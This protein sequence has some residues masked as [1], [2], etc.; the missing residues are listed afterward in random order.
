MPQ[1][2]KP[3]DLQPFPTLLAL[4]FC[5]H[6][7][8][9]RARRSGAAQG[10]ATSWLPSILLLALLLCAGLGGSP[11]L[12]QGRQLSACVRTVLAGVEVM[13]SGVG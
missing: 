4:R 1:L 13:W 7:Q 6:T 2:P 5:G 8:A 11:G 3:R 10:S 12:V 9:V